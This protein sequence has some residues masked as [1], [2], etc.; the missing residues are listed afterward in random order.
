VRETVRASGGELHVESVLG[1][2]TRISM[3]LP[4]AP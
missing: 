2:G 4:L 1:E 3:V